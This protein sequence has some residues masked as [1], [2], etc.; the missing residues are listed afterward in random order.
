MAKL[1][2]KFGG[3]VLKEIAID[4]EVITIGRKPGNNVQIDNLAVSGFHAKI[5]LE[6]GQYY[7]EDLNSTNGTFVAR[8]RVSRCPLRNN[9]DITVGKHTLVF[10][11]EVPESAESP[12]ATVRARNRSLDGTVM[13]KAGQKAALPERVESKGPTAEARTGVLTV[14]A[15]ATDKQVYE[16][17]ERLT[18][19]GS[20]DSAGIKLKGFFAPAVAALINRVRDEYIIHPPGSGRKPL[21]NGKPVEG[22]QVLHDGD[23]VDVG[24]VKMQ[25]TLKE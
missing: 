7:I 23:V 22:R 16:L 3:S 6:A 11:S 24:K 9:D 2:L 19:I 17:K 8:K 25:F 21:V 15:G 4:K 5:F 18:T 10:L 14:V 1:L 13:L 12:D 20:A